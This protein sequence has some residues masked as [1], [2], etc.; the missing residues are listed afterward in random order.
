MNDAGVGARLRGSVK[1]P[2]AP[3]LA[4]LLLL[5]L[6][7]V[8]FADP[9]IVERVRVT[10]FDFLQTLLPRSA[11]TGK[12]AIVDIDEASL[13]AVGQWPW[14]RSKIAELTAALA[15]MRPAVIGF[16]IL[17]PEP[18]RLSPSELVRVLPSIDASARDQL[19][20]L[21]SNDALLAR[22]FRSAPVVLAMAAEPAASAS[23]AD[24]A[25]P[26]DSF[27]FSDDPAATDHLARFARLIVS[28]RDLDTAAAGRGTVTLARDADGVVRRMGGAVVIGDDAFPTLTVEMARVA[29]GSKRIELETDPSGISGLRVG[30][31]SLPADETGHLWIRYARPGLEPIISA[32]DVLARRVDPAAIS[33]KLVLVGTTAAGVADYVATPFGN[34]LSGLEVHGQLLEGIIGGDLLN[35]PGHMLAVELLLLLVVGGAVIVAGRQLPGWRLLPFVC[36]VMM[37]VG[38]IALLAYWRNRLLLDPTFAF[39]VAI[40]L[41][42]TAV[43]EGILAEERARRRTEEELRRALIRAEAAS[44]AKSDFLANMSHELRTPL[45]AILGFS[46]TMQSGIFGPI[47][48]AK[49]A[50]YVN[51]IHSSGGHLLAIVSDVLDMSRIEAGEAKLDESEIDLAEAVDECLEMLRP[52]SEKKR[53]LIDCRVDAGIPRLRADRRMLKQMVLNLLTNAVTF[54]PDGGRVSVSAAVDPER[55]MAIS[56][57]DSGIGIAKSDL[58]RVMEP[59]HTV[60]RPQARSFQGIGLGLPLTR[61]MVEL[62]GGTLALDSQTGVGT[63]ATLTFPAARCVPAAAG[64]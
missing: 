32:S 5:L 18:D 40:L 3:R 14:P 59:F 10:F 26:P 12:V 31:R 15:E 61:S 19:L 33:G 43:T 47:A 2:G 51:K 4:L 22:S 54:T 39:I 27:V 42:M 7:A 20:R 11:N 44:K 49:Y 52:R 34:R 48:P 9:A 23:P 58:T 55:R 16:D 38:G 28:L 63:V 62:H 64:A 36:G 57:A 60:E 41:Y 50:D 1:R 46:E 17:F 29:A 37:L 35:R 53:M 8:R 56:I 13:H 30:D 6:A 24:S 45:T 21:P 25:M